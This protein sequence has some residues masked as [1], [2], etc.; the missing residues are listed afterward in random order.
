MFPFG[1]LDCQFPGQ[2]KFNHGAAVLEYGAATGDLVIVAG[3][4]GG[5]YGFG[6][7][8]EGHGLL[9][10]RGAFVFFI[11]GVGF[12][13]PFRQGAL[14]I[15]RIRQNYENIKL[16][17]PLLE[18]VK[19]ILVIGVDRDILEDTVRGLAAHDR[20]RLILPGDV[21]KMAARVVLP[22]GVDPLHQRL[23]A[24]GVVEGG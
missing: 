12:G 19:H 2:F 21:E 16:I 8:L 4:V 9:P 6:F 7:P 23:D 22:R 17:F 18:L 5:V 14:R 13:Y 20:E 24:F 10:K 3:C 1:F 11:S 15:R